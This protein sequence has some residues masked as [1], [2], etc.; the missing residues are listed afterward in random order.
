MANWL[1][2]WGYFYGPKIII[3]LIIIFSEIYVIAIMFIFYLV[4]KNIRKQ[5]MLNWFYA[6]EYDPITKSFNKLNL[7]KLNQKCSS[8]DCLYQFSF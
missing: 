3:D 1:G 7:T 5:K 4:S 2:D 8:S 6:M